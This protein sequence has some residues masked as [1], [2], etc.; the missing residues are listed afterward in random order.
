MNWSTNLEFSK[1][2]ESKKKLHINKLN[3]GKNSKRIMMIS[4]M[5]MR[6]KPKLLDLSSS[7]KL[8]K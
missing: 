4:K 3:L 7:F 1:T 5:P 2:N 6:P 8:L